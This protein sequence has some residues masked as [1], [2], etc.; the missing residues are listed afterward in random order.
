MK[1]LICIS[2]LKKGG[3]ERVVTNL[4]NYFIDNNDVIIVSLKSFQPE[5]QLDKKIKIAK[6][7]SNKKQN[8]ISKFINRIYKLNKIIKKEKPDIVLSFLPEPSFLVLLIKKIQRIKIIVSV[9]NDPKEEYRNVFYNIA[10]RL[11]YPKADGFVFQTEDAKSFFSSKIQKKSVVIMNPL[12]PEFLMNRFKG[13][14][15]KEIVAVGRLFEQKNHKLLIKSFSIFHKKHPDYT[16]TIYGEGPLRKELENLVE[17]LKIK[18]YVNLPGIEHD[19]KNK[20]Y[21]SSVFVLS[22][23]YEGMP[24]SL[25]EALTLG[26]PCIS[27]DCPCGGPRALIKDGINGVLTEVGNVE[28]FAEKLSALVE[29][30]EKLDNLSKNTQKYIKD[31]DPHKINK[32]WEEY[33]KKVLSKV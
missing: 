29:D 10:M 2:Q 17:K 12:N 24:N 6:L 19:I 21:Q 7:D 28:M 26:L 22:S 20:I 13:V 14:R 27:T 33:V 9:R 23:D 15:K 16:L 5:Y 25:M 32:E 31:I 4:A 1:I 30:K 11:L 3:A 8:K 18:D